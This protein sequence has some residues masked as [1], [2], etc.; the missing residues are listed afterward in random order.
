MTINYFMEQ[1]IEGYLLCDLKKMQEVELKDDETMG[2]CGYP[3][4][5]SIMAG[6]ELLGALT[7]NEKYNHLNG[8]TYFSNYWNT[9]LCEINHEYKPFGKFFRRMVRHGLMHSFLT[10]SDIEVSKNSPSLHMKYTKTPQNLKIDSTT[11]LNDFEKSYM[12]FIKPIVFE[13]KVLKSVDNHIMQNRLDEIATFYH[14]EAN[15][16]FKDL[17]KPISSAHYIT[18]FPK[19]GASTSTSTSIGEGWETFNIHSGAI[20]GSV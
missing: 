2:A 15:D 9:F 1:F 17:P 6:I 4:L 12:D 14:S 5:M 3:M 13:G 8:D 11:M 10:K 16:S 20:T 18:N 7:K 19:S